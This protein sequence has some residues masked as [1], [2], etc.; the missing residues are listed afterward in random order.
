MWEQVVI[1]TLDPHVLG[2]WWRDALDWV[3]VDDG[4]ADV[5]EIRPGPE[6]IPGLLFVRSPAAKVSKNRLHLDFRPDDQ[7]A[8]VERLLR[9]APS[10]RHRTGRRSLGRSLRPGRQ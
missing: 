10:G 3:V 5:F 2:R 7:A 9:S 4:D 8:E 1:E 6:Q